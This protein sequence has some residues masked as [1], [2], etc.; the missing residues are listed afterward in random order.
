M[1]AIGPDCLH[2]HLD[3]LNRPFIV[4]N[5][6]E[7]PFT[8]FPSKTNRKLSQVGMVLEARKESGAKA[9]SLRAVMEELAKP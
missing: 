3:P 2:S 4:N 8:L 9:E 1:D 5:S 7:I 6:N